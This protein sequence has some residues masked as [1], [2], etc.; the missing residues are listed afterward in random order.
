MPV[1]VSINTP[2]GVAQAL[3]SAI[4]ETEVRLLVTDRTADAV[5]EIRPTYDDTTDCF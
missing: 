1:R 4:A 2:G 5:L 3:A